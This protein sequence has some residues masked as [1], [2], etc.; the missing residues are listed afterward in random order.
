MT[1]QWL[2]TWG[3]GWFVPEYGWWDNTINID[4]AFLTPLVVTQVRVCVPAC[5]GRQWRHA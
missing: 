5:G 4:E 1:Q 3:L 2:R